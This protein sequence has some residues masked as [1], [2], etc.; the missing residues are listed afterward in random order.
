[1]TYDESSSLQ[2]LVPVTMIEQYESTGSNINCRASYSNF[3]PFTVDV[4]FDLGKPPGME[5]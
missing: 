2:M 4:K 1:M 3:R 5:D